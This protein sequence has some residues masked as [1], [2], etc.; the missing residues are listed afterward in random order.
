M[1]CVRPEPPRV[2]NHFGTGAGA[3]HSP[4]RVKHCASREG[5]AFIHVHTSLRLYSRCL[6][7]SGPRC[8][9]CSS[10]VFFDCLRRSGIESYHAHRRCLILPARVARHPRPTKSVCPALEVAW[11]RAILRLCTACVLDVDDTKLRRPLP[12]LA[13]SLSR[14]SLVRRCI[15]ESPWALTS[16]F[17]LALARAMLE[18]LSK[19]L[20]T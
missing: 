6:W 9:Y 5:Y 7:R 1:F 10:S 16:P 19:A 4:R 18:T 17:R 14:S 11:R 12:A 2:A 3:R 20:S 8:L 13:R 15:R